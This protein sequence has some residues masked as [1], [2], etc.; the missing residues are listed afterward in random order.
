MVVLSRKLL[1]C[2]EEKWSQ[3]RLHHFAKHD[4]FQQPDISTV[5][6]T[7]QQAS[8]K[9]LYTFKW[10]ECVKRK[11]TQIRKKTCAFGDQPEWNLYLL[12]ISQA[13]SMP[14]P[15]LG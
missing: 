2:I 5:S 4:K 11:H 6:L 13:T 15:E 8:E 12:I 9:V 10:S 7:E 1:N 3:Q 14:I